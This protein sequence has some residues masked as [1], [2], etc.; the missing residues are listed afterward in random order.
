MIVM[1]DDNIYLHGVLVC[2]CIYIVRWQTYDGLYI[3]VC[4]GV[5]IIQI[6]GRQG[7][8]PNN[9]NTHLWRRGGVPEWCI[10]IEK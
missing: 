2:A 8:C 1:L 4:G 7:V 6:R 5:L 10:F 3:G 9:I